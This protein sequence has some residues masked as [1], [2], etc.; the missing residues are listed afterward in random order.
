[1]QNSLLTK[2]FES[3]REAFEEVY[4]EFNIDSTPKKLDDLVGMWN[5]NWLLA[6]LFDDTKKALEELK[7]T[8]KIVLIANSDKASINNVLNKF[9]LTNLFD[10][11][12]LSC[13]LGVIKSDPEFL[14]K[15]VELLGT[16]KENVTVV[17]DS[18]QSDIYPAKDQQIKA[19][20]VDRKGNRE[21]TPKVT[22]LKNLKIAL[23]DN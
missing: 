20:L 2:N 13:N 15:V 22:T 1:M 7:Q 23:E 4:E 10:E 9:E 3:M 6:T 5:K 11:I 8:H 19:V 16:T 21:F 14:E 18:M 17:G 12:F